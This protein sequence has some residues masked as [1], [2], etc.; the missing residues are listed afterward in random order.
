MP[1]TS[2]GRSAAAAISAVTQQNTTGI[3]GPIMP[4]NLIAK[5]CASG[6]NGI[7]IWGGFPAYLSAKNCAERSCSASV[8][9]RARSRKALWTSISDADLSANRFLIAV[10]AVKVAGLT[11]SYG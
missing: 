2:L 9:N 5:R 3:F 10:P 11:L 7:M 6:L 4:R 1:V 8:E